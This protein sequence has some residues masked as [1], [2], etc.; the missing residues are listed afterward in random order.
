MKT[1]LLWTLALLMLAAP[2]AAEAITVSIQATRGNTTVTLPST[3]FPAALPTF[4]DSAGRPAVALACTNQTGA[5]SPVGT[6]IC[7]RPISVGG[8]TVMTITDVSVTNRARVYR[9][10]GLSSDILHLAGLQ[11]KSGSGITATSAVTL[12]ISYSSNEYAPLPYNL[13]AYTAAMSGNF[14]KTTG[15]IGAPASA[16]ASTT[17]CVTLKLTAN[18]VTVNQFGD[19]AVATVN[20]PPIGATGGLFGPPLN[21]SETKSIPCGVSGQAS[22]CNPLLRGELTAIYKGPAE[23]LKVVGGAAVGGS[24]NGITAGGVID[25]FVDV[26][27]PEFCTPEFCTPLD[28]FVDYTQEATLHALLEQDGAST[29]NINN[30]STVP[31]SWNLEKVVGFDTT[32]DSTR[33]RSIV[34]NADVFDNGAHVSFVPTPGQLQVR[35]VTSL[36]TSFVWGTLETPGDCSSSWFVELQLVTLEVIRI[37]LG[38]S[39]DF[40]TLCNTNFFN[41]KDLVAFGG[42]NVQLPDGSFTSYNS[43]KGKFGSVGIRAISVFLTA[44]TG[45]DQ[46][47][48]LTS[49]SIGAFGA[50]PFTR[51]GGQSPVFAETCDFPGLNEFTMRF[52][53]VDADHVPI[54]N[55]DVF[56]WGDE[57]ELGETFVENGCQLRSQV[58]VLRFPEGNR[59][60]FWR[61]ELLFNLVP[62]GQGFIKLI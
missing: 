41:D 43:M 24:N 25:T 27:A 50:P 14:F 9:V 15:T 60:G 33:L 28:V 56:V 32:L 21:A 12:K 13:Y 38:G 5:N 51:D 36:V 55:G 18:N 54:P 19:N 39:P 44:R 16:C 61:I 62:V 53:P 23:M 4:T 22:S 48:A 58:P 37:F 3:A 52:T 57:P 10:D 47:V 8:T 26:A 59:A 1:T 35:D 49:F 45:V 20:V 30:K 40:L 7:T 17:A 31:L 34:S 29:R 42:K 46:E 6:G 11:A 2:G